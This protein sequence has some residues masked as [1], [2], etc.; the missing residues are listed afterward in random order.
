MADPGAAGPRYSPF[1]SVTVLEGNH[2]ERMVIPSSSFA[3][4][5]RTSPAEA[6]L[7]SARTVRSRTEL[8]LVDRVAA[9]SRDRLKEQYFTACL[10]RLPSTCREFGVI[11]YYPAL[12]D[13]IPRPLN[14]KRGGVY[15][16]NITYR[17]ALNSALRSMSE[18]VLLSALEQVLPS[19]LGPGL[20]P[21][22]RLELLL[23]PRLELSLVSACLLG[24]RGL[25]YTLCC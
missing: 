4:R 20:P 18:Q 22:L 7:K 10:L 1:L 12:S 8:I 21:V 13:Q 24:Q 19:V 3:V 17:W 5:H 15:G 14:S 25:P 2:A 11:G 23:V 6:V 16:K 9:R